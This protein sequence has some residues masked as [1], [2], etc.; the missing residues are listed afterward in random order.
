MNPQETHFRSFIQL[1]GFAH[2][3]FIPQHNP[4]LEPPR[5]HPPPPIFRGH[6]I[7]ATGSR[8]ESYGLLGTP[9]LPDV[10]PPSHIPHLCC[11]EKT[12]YY[13]VVVKDY[14]SDKQHSLD[15]VRRLGGGEDDAGGLTTEDEEHDNRGQELTFVASKLKGGMEARRHC[16]KYFPEVIKAYTEKEGADDRNGTEDEEFG[17]VVC[18]G[19]MDV[20]I[21]IDVGGSIRDPIDF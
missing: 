17:A 19:K 9:L 11:L 12:L 15:F 1:D 10:H 21:G 20:R 18:M 2:L 16:E 13:K 3:C 4:E 14:D 5:H 6:L 8:S 7:V